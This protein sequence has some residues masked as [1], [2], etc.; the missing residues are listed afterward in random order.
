MTAAVALSPLTRLALLVERTLN[1][2]VLT[3]AGTNETVWPHYAR[4][5]AQPFSSRWNRAID[6]RFRAN[7]LRGI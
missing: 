7:F 1:D 2:A 5:A 4:K 3:G 6:H